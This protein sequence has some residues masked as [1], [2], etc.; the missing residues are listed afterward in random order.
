MLVGVTGVIRR[1]GRN[2]DVVAEQ[3]VE[4]VL[5]PGELYEREWFRPYESH[6]IA[7]LLRVEQS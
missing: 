6:E 2:S 5:I 7:A 3:A 1:A 4:V